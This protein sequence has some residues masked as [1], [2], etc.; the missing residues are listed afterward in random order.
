MYSALPGLY[1]VASCNEVVSDFLM[2]V[3]MIE[4]S[5]E[6]LLFSDDDCLLP[7]SSTATK[8]Y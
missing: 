8:I 6:A 2:K 5:N 4:S 1:S 3:S 7:Q